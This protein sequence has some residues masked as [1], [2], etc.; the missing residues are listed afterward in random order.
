MKNSSYLIKRILSGVLATLL[1][2]IALISFTGCEKGELI[3]LLDYY[4]QKDT[5][6]EL[7]ASCDNV[8]VAKYVARHTLPNHSRYFYEF[9]VTKSFCG[10]EEGE[11]FFMVGE[12]VPRELKVGREYYLFNNNVFYSYSWYNFCEYVEDIRIYADD[13][14]NSMLGGKPLAEM[15]ELEEGFDRAQLDAHIEGI[16]AQREVTKKETPIALETDMQTVLNASGNVVKAV[17]LNSVHGGMGDIATV[18]VLSSYK[19][20]TNVFSIIDIHLPCESVAKGK[21]YIFAIEEINDFN[22]SG[23]ITSR[24]G[25]YSAM[26]AKTVKEYLAQ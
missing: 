1:I 20:D 5:V 9:C 17:V 6:E 23:L 2:I 21:T 16:V 18:M 12:F 19:G 10:L 25:I 8:V 22:D 3:N 26:K 24:H 11:N 4:W 14:A 7:A 15:T 13:L